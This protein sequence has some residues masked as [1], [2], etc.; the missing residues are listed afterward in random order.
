MNDPVLVNRAS[1]SLRIDVKQLSDSCS[2]SYV[3][4][5][6]ASAL[7]QRR[8]HV[9]FLLLLPCDCLDPEVD[10]WTPWSRARTAQVLL[11]NSAHTEK[12][13]RLNQPGSACWT[14]ISVPSKS[15]WAMAARTLESWH[16]D[17]E[18]FLIWT[19]WS[20]AVRLLIKTSWAEVLPDLFACVNLLTCTANHW[21][22]FGWTIQFRIC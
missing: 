5:K 19:I 17:T 1:L 4:L 22:P 15:V 8:M 6:F 11:A 21:L 18:A 7:I 13:F 3:W 16:A 2:C 12:A 20:C 10:I 14:Q 9:Q